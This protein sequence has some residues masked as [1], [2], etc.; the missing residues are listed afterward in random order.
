M[1]TSTRRRR[2]SYDA[3]PRWVTPKRV[4]ATV[5]LIVTLVVVTFGVRL[6]F[7]LAKAF[8]TNPITAVISALQGGNGSSVDIAHRNLQR[9]NIM[10]YGY[11]GGGHDGA[12]L[13]DSL[14]LISIK[15]QASGPP[16]IAEI[17]IPRDWYVPIQ[18]PNDRHFGR[19]NEAYSDGMMG[20]GSV[21]AGQTNAGASIANPTLE[22]LLGVHIDHWVGV[23][24][25]A[26]QQA[27]DA[28]GGVDVNAPNTFTDTA[29]P[30]GE[31]DQGD[32][33]YMTVHFDAGTQHMDGATALI[34]A[35]SRHGTG[36]E[37]SD[38]A[39]SRR[40]QLIVAA[41]KQKA[42]SVGGIGSLPDLLN[43]LGDNVLTD[44][45]IGDAEALY[46]LV[47]DVDITKVE[48]ISIDNTNFLYDCGYPNR[49]GAYYLYAHDSTFHTLGQFMNNVF[50][51]TDAL[52]EHAQV[53]F[54][55]GSGRRSDASQRWTALMSELG[56]T[57]QDGG[58]APTQTATAVIDRSG[59]KD[60]KTAK[61]LAAYFGVPV[62]TQA[63]ASPSAGA[64]AGAVPTNGGIVV[65]LGGAEESAFGG[66][67]GVGR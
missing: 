48:H 40:Q 61:W 13:T 62:T 63:P 9:I 37:G 43:A 23:N 60:A 29:Y 7:A 52:G 3:V 41:L 36:A 38:F 27:V 21:P 16:Q 32:C 8:N 45:K 15:P 67:P 51:T 39:R 18:L 28:V 57:T 46:G 10:L 56:F 44:L 5:A 1:A 54:Q 47:K 33:S 14:M 66:N 34:F 2:S 65:V 58:T 24:F 6:S 59:G 53:T 55:D 25:H 50:P 42:V 11:G 30:H 19:I 49:C 31:C 26:F 12:F 35:R 4:I 64:S 22:H 20:Q 17:S